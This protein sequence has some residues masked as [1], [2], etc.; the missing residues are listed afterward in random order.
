M[1]DIKKGYNDP[2]DEGN[3]EKYHTGKSCIE[4]G[5][6]NPAGTFWSP[7]WCF[8]CNVKRTDR[9]TEQLTSILRSFK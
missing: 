4:E 9:I 8:E 7:Y 5:C 2:E 6:S 1:A 3:S